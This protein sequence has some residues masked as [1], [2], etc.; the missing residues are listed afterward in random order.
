MMMVKVV[1]VVMGPIS[2]VDVN[3]DGGYYSFMVGYISSYSRLW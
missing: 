3:Y 1:M 2:V